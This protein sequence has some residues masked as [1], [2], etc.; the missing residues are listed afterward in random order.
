MVWMIRLFWQMYNRPIQSAI[1]ILH[2]YICF[3]LI[4]SNC[5]VFVLITI[6]Q[7]YFYFSTLQ[8]YLY[9]QHI[10][11]YIVPSQWIWW[12]VSLSMSVC[13]H[14]HHTHQND[15]SYSHCDFGVHF[16]N[17][18]RSWCVSEPGKHLNISLWWMVWT[19]P[20]NHCQMIHLIL[21]CAL[22]CHL[23]Q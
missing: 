14:T 16:S 22:L 20:I 3:D 5:Y 4:W 19:T 10:S 12:S 6:I 13:I 21:V 15:D 9:L 1:N 7:C 23:N 11:A 18:Y 8:F 2:E 17:Y